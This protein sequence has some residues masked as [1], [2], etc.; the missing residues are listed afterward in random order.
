MTDTPR[1]PATQETPAEQFERY[2]EFWTQ[3]CAYC[4][5]GVELVMAELG[6]TREQAL[7]QWAAMTYDNA[8]NLLLRAFQTF[9]EGAKKNK[10]LAERQAHF[11][12]EMLKHLDEEHHKPWEDKP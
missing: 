11:Q 6:V 10:E 5:A 1:D 4:R 12:D 8:A 2:R 9:E 3:K 7:A